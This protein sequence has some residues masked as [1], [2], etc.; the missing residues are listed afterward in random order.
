MNE[1]GI[2]ALYET[3][4]KNSLDSINKLSAFDFSKEITQPKPNCPNEESK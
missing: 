2:S 3:S 4:K 1:E